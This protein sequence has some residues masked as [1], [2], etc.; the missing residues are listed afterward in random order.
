MKKTV[1]DIDD[2]QRLAP[3]FKK[4]WVAFLAKQLMKWLNIDK[5]NTIHARY[6]HLRGAVGHAG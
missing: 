4:K 2:L 5:V 1:L 6:S 3:V